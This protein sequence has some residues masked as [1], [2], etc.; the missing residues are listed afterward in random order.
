MMVHM[1]EP[2]I[3]YV[4]NDKGETTA[5]IVP[6]EEWRWISSALE[7]QHLLRSPAMAKRLT[8]A[9]KRTGGRPAEEAVEKLGL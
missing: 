1:A 6:L 9:M 5:V 3:Q 2:A 7:T 8:E 4:Q